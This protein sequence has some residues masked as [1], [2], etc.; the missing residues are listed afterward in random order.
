MM[1]RLVRC[2]LSAVRGHKFTPVCYTL[3]PFLEYLSNYERIHAFFFQQENATAPT[4]NYS[5]HCL[6]S[7]FDDRMIS[8]KFLFVRYRPV[9][10]FTVEHVKGQEGRKHS[11]L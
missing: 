11:G 8:R 7:V 1:L 5:V 2:A 6:E 9:P 10:C 4:K 3:A